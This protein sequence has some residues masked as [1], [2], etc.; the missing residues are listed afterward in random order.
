MIHQRHYRYTGIGQHHRHLP[1]SPASIN[2]CQQHTADAVGASLRR[3]TDPPRL[4]RMQYRVEA[5][6]KRFLNGLNCQ[7]LQKRYFSAMPHGFKF[8]ANATSPKLIANARPRRA[9]IR[10]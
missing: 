1:T 5:Q 8:A 4:E 7:Y 9:W 6:E 3:S 10:W 2:T